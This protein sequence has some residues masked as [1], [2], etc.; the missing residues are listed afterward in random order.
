MSHIVY[1]P[2]DGESRTVTVF[3]L[4][5]QAGKPVEVGAD[6]FAR[7][8]TNPTFKVA[9]KAAAPVASATEPSPKAEPAKVDGRSKAARTA[10]EEEAKARAA[11]HAAEVAE[12]KA[13]EKED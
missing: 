10:R 1:S 3:G 4:T 11:A 13:S 9:S 6:V 8:S 7:L 12:A 5:F 2:A